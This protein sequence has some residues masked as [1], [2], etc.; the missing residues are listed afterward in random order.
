[1]FVNFFPPENRAFC[2]IVWKK[3]GAAGQAANDNIIYS[4]C[5]LDN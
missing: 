1:M 5:M 2:E 3:Y 4:P